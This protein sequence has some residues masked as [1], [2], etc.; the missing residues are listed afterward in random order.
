MAAE[1]RATPRKIVEPPAMVNA[2]L[3]GFR[4]SYQ[5]A[6]Y[7]DLTGGVGMRAGS[8]ALRSIWRALSSRYRL[9]TQL[10][11]PMLF[12]ILEK[13]RDQ[14]RIVVGDFLDDLETK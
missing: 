4:Q 5:R 10:R 7:G 11:A 12:A 1:S 6:V 13:G 3:F 2:W 9:G 8:S 14:Q